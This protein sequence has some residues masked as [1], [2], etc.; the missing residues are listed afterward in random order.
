MNT[1]D[2]IIALVDEMRENSQVQRFWK[3]VPLAKECIRLL[4][5]LDDPE[6]DS[7]GKAMVCNAI[8]EQLPEY[9]MPRFVLDILHYEREL[10]VEA[11][12]DGC[13]DPEA[14]E[15]VD[16]DIQRLNDYIDI[17]HVDAREFQKRY[18]RMLDFDPVERTPEWE[19]L[20][21]EVEEE[22]DRRLGD[23]PRGMGFCFAYWSVRREV[24]AK[25]GIQWQSPAAMNPHVMFD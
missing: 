15:A 12:K 20:Y 18:D 8:C 10:L 16:F 6:E 22:C 21:C 24:L 5:D 25:H 2:K 17:R 11:E 1:A 9:D 19:K 14:L 23:A 7:Q 13:G 4:H 3:N